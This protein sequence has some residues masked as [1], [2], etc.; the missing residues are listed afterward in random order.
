MIEPFVDHY[1]ALQKELIGTAVTEQPAA[2]E[3]GLDVTDPNELLGVWNLIDEDWGRS[4]TEEDRERRRNLWGCLR[5]A[6]GIHRPSGW[7][8]YVAGIGTNRP[9]DLKEVAN[10]PEDPLKTWKARCGFPTPLT[11][12]RNIDVRI[13]SFRPYSNL[14]IGCRFKSPEKKNL[15]CLAI[16]PNDA[17]GALEYELT[18]P[19]QTAAVERGSDQAVLGTLKEGLKKPAKPVE[20]P[21]EDITADE[22]F[23]L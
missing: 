18:A 7:E 1:H 16:F 10:T 17:R 22:R 13:L 6:K 19:G 11:F 20:E 9:L 2:F 3:N 14:W 5:F 8:G 15:V 23:K 4:G 21:L 12:Y